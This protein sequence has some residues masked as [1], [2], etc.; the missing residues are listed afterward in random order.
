MD[1]ILE[2]RVQAK[3]LAEIAGI[4]DHPWADAEKRYKAE[5]AAEKRRAAE[6][7]ERKEREEAENFA[8]VLAEYRR[9]IADYKQ[10][11]EAITLA[12]AEKAKLPKDSAALLRRAHYWLTSFAGQAFRSDGTFTKY[13]PSDV[14]RVWG[15][16]PANLSWHDVYTAEAYYQIDVNQ[17]NHAQ[18]T[19]NLSTSLKLHEQ[20]Y[21]ALRDIRESEGIP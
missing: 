7:A 6:E 16:P 18:M 10:H 19:D 2:E 21:P 14:P 3:K 12:E 4:A 9:I 8:A 20:R 11:R 13:K 5:Q 17:K 15:P 1:P